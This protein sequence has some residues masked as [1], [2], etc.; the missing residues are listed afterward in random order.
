MLLRRTFERFVLALLLVAAAPVSAATS[1][2]A[3]ADEYELKAAYLY[4]FTK[5]IEWPKSSFASSS[6]S[7]KL[8]VIS[9]DSTYGTIAKTLKGKTTQDRKISVEHIDWDEDLTR[10]HM[11]FVTADQSE[12][13]EK[14]LKV[15]KENV[16]VVGEGT[17]FV[18][19]YGDFAFLI[20][21]S[22]VVF[23]ASHDIN[24]RKSVK[25]SSKLLALAVTTE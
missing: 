14:L 15:R 4:N 22:R 8:G 25:V 13:Y 6:T 3:V 19:K 23:Q 20:R 16:V 17:G 11:L 2:G 12:S 1:Y 9:S 24:K 10:F 7:L 5:F 21:N 18:R